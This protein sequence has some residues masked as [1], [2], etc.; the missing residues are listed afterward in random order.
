MVAHGQAVAHGQ[1]AVMPARLAR[2]GPTPLVVVVRAVVGVAVHQQASPMRWVEEQQCVHWVVVVVGVAIP[3]TAEDWGLEAKAVVVAD[4]R[5][6]AADPAV[7]VAVAGRAAGRNEQMLQAV[8]VVAV[9]VVA[10]AAAP[11]AQV[12]SVAQQREQ[13]QGPRSLMT[14]SGRASAGT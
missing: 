9:V 1:V 3:W 7:A 5:Q 13:A 8:A 10:A 12:T 14:C 2:W 4:E 6:T 11:Q